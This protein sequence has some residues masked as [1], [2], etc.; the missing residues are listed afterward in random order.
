ME[1]LPKHIQIVNGKY[2]VKV[3][4]KK[5]YY[6]FGQ[7]ETLQEAENALSVGKKDLRF[8]LFGISCSD[9][10]KHLNDP[11]YKLVPKFTGYRLSKEGK[12]QSNRQNSL[13]MWTD[14]KVSLN[15][16]GY[17]TYGLRGPE[18]SVTKSLHVLLYTTYVGEIPL[19]YNVDH[20]DRNKKNNS[21]S[22]LRLANATSDSMYNVGVYKSS[23]SGYKGVSKSRTK[24][25]A[26]IKKDGIL[27]NLGYFNCKH[28]AAKTYNEAAKN[29]HGDFAYLNTI[30]GDT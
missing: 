6:L 26:K 20:I 17:Y 21:I 29:L 25:H 13:D 3:C 19:G 15:P 2:L 5:N 7:Y 4:V 27:Y 1:K 23:T 14:C 30:E 28:K 8:K 18:K 10:T 9:Y 12:L 11:T 22:N 24:Y 16:S